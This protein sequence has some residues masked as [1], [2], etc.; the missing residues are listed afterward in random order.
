MHDTRAS[1]LMVLAMA[2]FAIEDMFVKFL[3]H[4]LPVG[5]ILAIAGVMGFASFWMICGARAAGS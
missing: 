5:E 2:F 4:R 1:A 3:S